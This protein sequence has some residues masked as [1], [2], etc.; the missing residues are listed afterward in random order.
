MRWRGSC[1]AGQ[2]AGCEA[3]DGER[4]IPLGRLLLQV[5]DGE[6]LYL[7]HSGCLSCVLS[8][9]GRTCELFQ[10][11]VFVADSVSGLCKNIFFLCITTRGNGFVYFS[12]IRLKPGM[13]YRYLIIIKA[14]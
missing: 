11:I 13:N 6:R 5:I 10:V 12:P 8:T 2:R 9:N 3:G 1:R 14:L 7:G 4:W